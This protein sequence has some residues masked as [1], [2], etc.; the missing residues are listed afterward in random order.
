MHLR[1]LSEQ[2][3]S[4]YESENIKRPHHNLR[5]WSE[6]PKSIDKSENNKRQDSLTKAS[7]CSRSHTT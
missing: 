1:K 7:D 5:K 2:H 3:N 6:K 4:I